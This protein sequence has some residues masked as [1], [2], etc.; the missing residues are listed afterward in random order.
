MYD[1]GVAKTKPVNE[2]DEV[3][4]GRVAVHLHLDTSLIEGLDGWVADLRGAGTP[5][6]SAITRTALIRDLLAAA[7]AE[8]TRGKVGQLHKSV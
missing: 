6:M 7:V 4:P 5:G 3:A 8:R 2:R 1:S